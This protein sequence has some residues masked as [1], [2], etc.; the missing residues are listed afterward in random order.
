VGYS[1]NDTI[2]VLDRVRENLRKHQRS[3][4]ANLLNRSINETLPRTVFTGSTALG[5]LVALAVLGGEVVRSFALVML[6]GV[7]IGTFSSMFIA[8]PVLLWIEKK[9]PGAQVKQLRTPT[10]QPPAPASGSVGRKTQPVG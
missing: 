5:S 2:V 7:I 4:F 8:S 9:W 1:L 3:D 6:Y 10:K